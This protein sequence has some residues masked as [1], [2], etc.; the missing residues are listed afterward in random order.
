MTFHKIIL[1]SILCFFA[2]TLFSQQASE[3]TVT[4]HEIGLRFSGFD[5]FNLMYKKGLGEDRYRRH[6]FLNARFQFGGTGNKEFATSLGYAFGTEK[7][8]NIT[9]D[10]HFIH[11][12][13][14]AI[15]L[16]YRDSPNDFVRFRSVNVTP[17]IGYVLGFLLEINDS[18]YI[19]AEVI[20]ALSSSILIRNSGSNSYNLDLGG[21]TN[22]T[23]LNLMY[24]FSK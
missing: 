18:F 3:S 14:I 1:I 9:K 13:E 23:G 10:L 17:S 22:G 4:N 15:S 21:S 16:S 19:S 6:R 20:P 7:R 8:K 24:R 2:V 5:D 12:P 11:G